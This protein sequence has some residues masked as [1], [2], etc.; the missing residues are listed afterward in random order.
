MLSWANKLIQEYTSGRQELRKRAD[1][2]DR[3]N[4]IE[5]DDLKQINS[6]I[7]SKTFSLEWMTDGKAARALSR[8]R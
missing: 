7:V 5:M 6:M 4:P 1:Q 8:N 2:I 3:N